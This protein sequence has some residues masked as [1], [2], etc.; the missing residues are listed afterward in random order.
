MIASSATEDEV[1]N[2]MSTVW[3]PPLGHALPLK[4]SLASQAAIYGGHALRQGDND[5]L[6][7]WG[8]KVHGGVAP[9]PC[10]R[11]L[12]TDLAAVGCYDIKVDGDYGNGTNTAVKRF[13]WCLQNA[14]HRTSTRM[15]MLQEIRRDPSI[16]VTGTVDHATARHLRSWAAG[17]YEVT[18][19]L[20]VVPLSKYG[21]FRKG[22]LDR[23]EH[24]SVGEDEMVVHK[25]FIAGLEAINKAAA[26]AGVLFRVNQTLRIAGEPV[27]GAVVRPAS[28]SQHLVGN[29]VDFNVRHDG[30]TIVSRDMRWADLPRAV[31]DFITDVKDAGLRWGGDWTDPWDPIH[32]DAL[33]DPEGFDFEV[34]YFLN[35]RT[36]QKKQA[37][38]RVT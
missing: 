15:S 11:E 1:H 29:A 22:G 30:T 38:L 36:I 19:T 8:G 3:T 9:A 20:R 33:I 6:R 18:G 28:K 2:A 24:L 35:Q 34:L 14:T 21:E 31:K 27:Q 25:D 32:F 13:Q 5:K 12:Q 17:G 16:F 26:D 37:I 23:I 4:Q 10:V 7:K